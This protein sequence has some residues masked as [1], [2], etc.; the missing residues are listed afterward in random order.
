MHGGCTI[1]IAQGA[2][3]EFRGLASARAST[4][5]TA[6]L[7]DRPFVQ[8]K[9]GEA[10]AIVRSA[11]AFLHDAIAQAWE[12]ATEQPEDPSIEIANLRLAITHAGHEAA[13]AVDL[14]FQAAGT[15]AAHTDNRLERYFRDS[16]VAVQHGA[17]APRN[18]E[19][20]GRVFLGLPA[21]VGGW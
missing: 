2:L 14:V 16:H 17:S 20:A 18:Y 12:A 5:Q 11:R 21:G 7:R 6:L 4:L 15:N 19:T 3:D 13:R 8:N 1:G 9:I 10:E